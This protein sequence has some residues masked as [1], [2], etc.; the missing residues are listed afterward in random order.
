MTTTTTRRQIVGAALAVATLG[1]GSAVAYPL[2][3]TIAAQCP[4]KPAGSP[5]V[6]PAATGPD[7]RISQPPNPE[8]ALSQPDPIFGAIERHRVTFM[9][10]MEA[11]AALSP[12][13][14]SDPKRPEL[15]RADND[16]R[17]VD[18]TAALELIGVMPTTMAGVLALLDYVSDFN[19]GK[20][21]FKNGWQSAPYNWPPVDAFD[22]AGIEIDDDTESDCGMAFAVL[23]NVRNA[24][25]A[26]AVQS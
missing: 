25:A 23:L 11:G 7:A 10:R 5:P 26:M 20:F 6:S 9:R 12:V 16:A 19:Q 24:L 2:A 18:E 1:A 3:E 21:R 14:H 13:R 4:A 22:F 17:E 8:G 15:E